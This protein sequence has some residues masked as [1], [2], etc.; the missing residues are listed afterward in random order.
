M[1]NIGLLCCTLM[2]LASAA[3]GKSAEPP[4]DTEIV[5]KLVNRM[6]FD[7]ALFFYERGRDASDIRIAYTGDDYDYPVYSIA[8]ARGCV[9]AAQPLERCSG[10]LTARMISASTTPDMDRPRQRGKA[11]VEALISR[12]ATEHA[13]I[14]RLL[15][16]LGVKWLETD[17]H[18]CPNATTVL[19]KSASLNWVPKEI[20]RHGNRDDGSINIIVHADQVAVTFEGM[21]RSSTY[22]GYLADGSPAVWA[23]ELAAVLEPCWKPSTATP[24]WNRTGRPRDR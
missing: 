11:L 19:G 6:A 20:S 7:P 18:S 9:T 13:K 17:F 21:A 4:S 15:P 10:R 2:G 22:R 16:K 8:I 12:D 3:P 1:K 24:P 23:E 14:A 5:T